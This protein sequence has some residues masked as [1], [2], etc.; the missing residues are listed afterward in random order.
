MQ[1]ATE[2][3]EG[4]AV[5]RR[6]MDRFTDL[7]NRVAAIDIP[8]LRC[9]KAVHTAEL[10][11]IELQTLTARVDSLRTSFED[12]REKY[13]QLSEALGAVSMSEQLYARA[14]QISDVKQCLKQQKVRTA[15]ATKAIGKS[16][17]DIRVALCR[18]RRP[19]Q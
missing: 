9:N 19:M 3:E 2:H 8:E 18:T 5:R 11:R 7:V 13:E 4:G 12:I 14:A 15:E 17:A 1:L 16:K 10:E 6:K